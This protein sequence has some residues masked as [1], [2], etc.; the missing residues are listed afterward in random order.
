M[1]VVF[2]FGAVL[3]TWQPLRFLAECFPAQADNAAHTGHLAHA[4]F[5]HEDWQ[6]YDCGTI[7]MQEVI[8]RTSIRLSL[9]RNVLS[10]LV[11]S[12]GERLQP[13]EGSIALLRR[14]CDLRE[15]QTAKGGQQ[16]KLYFLSNMP[17]DYARVLEREYEF[18]RWFD[19]GIFS[20]DVNLVKP[21]PEIYQLLQQRY[22]LEASQT[23]FVDDLLGNI[24]TAQSLGWDGVLFDSV[25]KVERHINSWL[26]TRLG[27]GP[28]L[29]LQGA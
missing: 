7:S 29:S 10:R 2:D 13:M 1:N 23:L 9:D 24:R 27:S 5:G 15:R 3:V 22:G 28:A 17:T 12:I 4:V 6:A 16:I 25:S 20:G 26:E 14:L 19:G 8:D 18:V 21:D 11:E